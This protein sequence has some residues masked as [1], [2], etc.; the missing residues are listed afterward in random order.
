MIGHTSTYCAPWNMT[1]SSLSDFSGN[2]LN[3]ILSVDSY[4]F[5]NLITYSNGEGW[6][7]IIPEMTDSMSTGYPKYVSG[8]EYLPVGA[9]QT[10]GYMVPG[11]GYWIFMKDDGTYAS[12]ESVYNLNILQ[13]TYS[14]NEMS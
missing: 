13:D 14:G 2:I 10:D 3:G 1:L 9:L 8:T 11:Q 4:K 7:G 12:I 5:S 6:G